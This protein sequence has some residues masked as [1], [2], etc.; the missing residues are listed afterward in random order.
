MLHIM[1]ITAVTCY[2][3][4]SLNS[5]YEFPEDGRDVPKHVEVLKDSSDLFV[6]LCICLVFS[7]NILNKVGTAIAQWLRCCATNRKVAGSIP[8]DITGIFH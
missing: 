8:D 4:A 7:A 3:S 6:I 2:T 1:N 5:G